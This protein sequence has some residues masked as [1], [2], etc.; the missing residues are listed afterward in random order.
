[1]KFFTSILTG[2]SGFI[3]RYLVEKLVQIS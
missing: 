1:M 3:G 2:V